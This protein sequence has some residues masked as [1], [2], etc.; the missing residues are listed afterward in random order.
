MGRSA[1]RWY[2][3]KQLFLETQRSCYTAFRS[4]VLIVE[5]TPSLAFE[6][7]VRIAKKT[8][9]P[10]G[11]KPHTRWDYLGPLHLSECVTAPVPGGLLGCY[12]YPGKKW[13]DAVC[14]IRPESAF[15]LNRFEWG[16]K[17]SPDNLYC[18]DLVYFIR[19]TSK[20]DLGKVTTGNYVVQSS[21]R[22][23]ILPEAYRLAVSSRAKRLL[24]QA[25]RDVHKN[26]VVEFVGINDI[27]PMYQKVSDGMELNRTV[28]R[29]QTK[30]AI[31]RLLP[32]PES[33][34]W[35]EDRGH[36]KSGSK[37]RGQV[38]HCNIRSHEPAV[39]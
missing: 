22:G 28:Q 11:K 15:E 3:I 5:R 7:A 12:K 21:T 34:V 17:P 25:R 10:H 18:V 4:D 33:L 39:R 30:K 35:K 13:A 36:K 20:V 38:L 31:D 16:P 8:P 23:N 32:P 29:Y 26:S 37:S 14:L 24:I 6:K 2:Q 9:H 27:T 1:E 19:R